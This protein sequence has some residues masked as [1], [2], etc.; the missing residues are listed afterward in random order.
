MARETCMMVD[1]GLK[2]HGFETYRLYEMVSE[3]RKVWRRKLLINYLEQLSF[4]K[5]QRS[6]F[7][8]TPLKS[9]YD[10]LW[11]W[12]ESFCLRRGRGFDSLSLSNLLS[13]ECGRHLFWNKQ[14]QSNKEANGVC[15]TYL[16]DSRQLRR[17]R[18]S[19]F[20]SKQKQPPIQVNFPK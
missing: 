19:T 9:L 11:I 16:R 5:F 14:L 18:R 8:S 13:F 7:H 15:T 10:S 1:Q 4:E 20:Y 6:E 12:N 3:P 17:I 2:C